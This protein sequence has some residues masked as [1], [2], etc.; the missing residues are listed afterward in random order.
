M[1]CSMSSNYV[2]GGSTS[3]EHYQDEALGDIRSSLHVQATYGIP[4]DELDTVRY[5]IEARDAGA[6]FLRDVRTGRGFFLG[7]PK[8]VFVIANHIWIANQRLTGPSRRRGVY[9]YEPAVILLNEPI[10]CRKTLIHETLHSASLYSRIFSIFPD[11]TRNHYQ[12]IEGI[13]E[14]LVGYVLLD[15][16]P[17]CYKNWKTNQMDRC[18]ISYIN[19]VKL[20]CSLCQYVGIGDLAGFYL[21]QHTSLAEPWQT[22]LQAIRNAGFREFDF[23]LEPRRAFNEPRFR[24]VC[25]NSFPDFRETYES[26]TKCLDF[27]QIP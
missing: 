16:H 22:L 27:S 25:M 3:I 26:S 18:S 7:A 17:D 1:Q 13:T 24:D 6:L 9:L 4:N 19:R 5:R 21:S 20:W 10:W 2:N 11:I 23:D 15:R 12:L 14:C 8:R